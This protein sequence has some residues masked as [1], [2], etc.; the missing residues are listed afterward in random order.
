MEEKTARR[1]LTRNR[2]KI[3]QQKADKGG[4]WRPKGFIKTCIKILRNSSDIV[5]RRVHNKIIYR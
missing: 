3:A 2:W 4:M 1:F 5:S